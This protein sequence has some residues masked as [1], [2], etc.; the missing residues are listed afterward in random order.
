MW[1]DDTSQ[2]GPAAPDGIFYQS[3]QDTMTG[4]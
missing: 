3:R 1:Y 4:V 2:R